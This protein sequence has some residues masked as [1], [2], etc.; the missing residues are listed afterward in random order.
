LQLTLA[1]AQI[2]VIDLQ[3]RSIKIGLLGI[4]VLAITQVCEYAITNCFVQEA[5]RSITENK[6]NATGM[7]TAP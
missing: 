2:Q 3:F 6:L 4:S 1:A 7:S 5:C